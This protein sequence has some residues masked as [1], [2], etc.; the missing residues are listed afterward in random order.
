MEY[1]Y[2]GEDAIYGSFPRTDYA[3]YANVW[4]PTTMRADPTVT[5]V[6]SSSTAQGVSRNRID[7]YR[8]NG[9]PNF[10]AGH[11]ASAEL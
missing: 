4:F 3:G 8:V 5:G 1:F 2:K 10:D 7:C 9:Y 6:N 11:T